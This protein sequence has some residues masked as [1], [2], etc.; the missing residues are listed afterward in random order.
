MSMPTGKYKKNQCASY[1]YNVRAGLEYRSVLPCTFF[2]CIPSRF[3]I[4]GTT[5][6]I[7][8]CLPS[9]GSEEGSDATRQ[10]EKGL[11]RIASVSLAKPAPFVTVGLESPLGL[12]LLRWTDLVG[13]NNFFF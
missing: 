1:F 8:F 11:P 4:H 9:F 3:N 13:K 7:V 2:L 5:N 6:T 12:A 10:K